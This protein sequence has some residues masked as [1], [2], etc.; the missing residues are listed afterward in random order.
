MSPAKPPRQRRPR[1]LARVAQRASERLTQAKE[2][3]FALQLGAKSEQ[4]IT[5][6]SASLIEPRARS[7]PCPRCEGQLDLLTHEAKS[8][9]GVRLRRIS[10]K[11]RNC[12]HPRQLWFRIVGPSLN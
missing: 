2:R 11:C 12:G 10:L 9:D 8:I 5:V 7:V 4:P 1:T 3:W 6:T